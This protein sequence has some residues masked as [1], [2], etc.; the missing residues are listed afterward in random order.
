MALDEVF[1]SPAVETGRREALVSVVLAVVALQV[2][3]TLKAGA[4]YRKGH[5]MT[6]LGGLDFEGQVYKMGRI[7][8]ALVLVF[9]ASLRRSLWL[10]LSS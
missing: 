10:R 7:R 3:R 5:H 1:A 8:Y 9:S 2:M 6:F 4:K